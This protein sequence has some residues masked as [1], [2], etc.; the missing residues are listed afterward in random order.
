MNDE[1]RGT[2]DDDPGTNGKEPGTNG[3]NDEEPGVDLKAD[4]LANA[5]GWK[6]GNFRGITSDGSEPL[7]DDGYVWI[8]GYL[9]GLDGDHHCIYL[10]ASGLSWLKVRTVD[11][12]FRQKPPDNDADRRSGVLLRRKAKVI[13]CR[14]SYAH[15][16]V[17]EVGGVDPGGTGIRPHGPPY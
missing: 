13:Q 2:N 15:D 4:A 17:D 11:I 1:L 7:T 8:K 3:A 14:V 16:I 6:P 5:L 10:D 12:K 9:A